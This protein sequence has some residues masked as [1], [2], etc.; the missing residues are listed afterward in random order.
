MMGKI[1]VLIVI[2]IIIECVAFE[3]INDFM[4]SEKV[5]NMMEHP[6]DMVMH[7]KTISF[8]PLS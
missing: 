3:T 8:E 4:I 6:R 1:F 7:L 2:I 5:N